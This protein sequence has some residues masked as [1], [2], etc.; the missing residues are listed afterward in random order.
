[1]ILINCRCV[2]EKQ[3][4]FALGIQWIIIRCLGEW[5]YS[6]GKLCHGLKCLENRK[7]KFDYLS[8]GAMILDGDPVENGTL[9]F[10]CYL[11]N[12]TSKILCDVI[13]FEKLDTVAGKGCFVLHWVLVTTS[14]LIQKNVLATSID[15]NVLAISSTHYTCTFQTL[16]SIISLPLLE[17]NLII[18]RCL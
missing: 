3:R 13:R 7:T 10:Y 4:S 1:M 6:A 8:N 17:K 14:N 11:L 16:M 12:A 5:E 2:P 18:A 9:P 15:E